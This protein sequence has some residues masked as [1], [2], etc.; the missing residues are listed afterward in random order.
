M[1]RIFTSIKFRRWNTC[2]SKKQLQRLGSQKSARK[3]KSK[4]RYEQI[5]LD[6]PYIAPLIRSISSTSRRTVKK[7]TARKKRTILDVVAPRNFSLLNNAEEFLSF[8]ALL[9]IHNRDRQR[10]QLV[11]KDTE[12]I[13]TDAILVLRAVISEF[14]HNGVYF[15]GDIPSNKEVQQVLLESG[16]FEELRINFKYE[17][18]TKN[19]IKTH[20]K[21]RVES[22]LTSD[23]I[24]QAAETVW[25]EKKRCNGIQRTLIECMGNTFD[26]AWLR[27]SHRECWFLSVYHNEQERKV[28]FAFVDLGV[29]IFESIKRKKYSGAIKQFFERVSGQY[30]DN[31][32]LLKLIIHEEIKRTRSGDKHRGRGL[33]GIYKAFERNQLSNLTIISNNVFANF[34]PE[35]YR[36]IKNYFV[37]T[38]IYWELHEDNESLPWVI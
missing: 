13:T 34:A 24:A 17:R 16:F 29:G 31:A 30:K 37:G 2:K 23:L 32:E 22:A 20:K 14:H 9:R 36:L 8:V 19:N 26:H 15:T 18:N 7:E 28:S 4:F 5:R 10:V 11:M 6:K 3:R 25:N 35:N 1:K 12:K 21:K 38:F 27:R 33:P